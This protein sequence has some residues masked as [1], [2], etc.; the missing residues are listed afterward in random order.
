MKYRSIKLWLGTYRLLKVLA[1][2]RGETLTALVDRMARTADAAP[3]LFGHNEDGT[4]TFGDRAYT[5]SSLGSTPLGLDR[6]RAFAA[7]LNACVAPSSDA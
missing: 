6:A 5:T 3:T 7:W 1:A 4:I 2:Q